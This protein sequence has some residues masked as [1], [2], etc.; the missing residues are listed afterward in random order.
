MARWTDLKKIA[1]K[2]NC[3][4]DHLTYNGPACYE[5]IIAG[6][7]QG[8]S[9]IVYV[10]E[11]MNEKRRISAYA[12]NGSHLKEVIDAHLKEGWCLYY[13]SQ[14]T[15]DKQRAFDMQNRFLR[16]YDY[17]WNIVGAQH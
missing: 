3:F 10:G 11:T 14:A 15:L 2:K 8:N 12:K 17:S 1:D 16:K 7:R 5:L 6:P 4:V 9:H 13:R